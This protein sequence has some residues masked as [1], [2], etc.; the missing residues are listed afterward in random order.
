MAL[1]IQF[2]RQ[3]AIQRADADRLSQ[4]R[5]AADLVRWTQPLPR[6]PAVRYGAALTRLQREINVLT[7]AALKPFI[8]VETA[9][10]QD[11]LEPMDP[12]ST[13]LTQITK[14]VAKLL[15]P[16]ALR[17]I[18]TPAGESVT[19]WNGRKYDNALGDVL[20]INDVPANR[21][22][23][24]F[25]SWTTEN[26]AL[27]QGS[28]QEQINKIRA[29]MF[30][31]QRQGQRASD[32]ENQIRLIMESTTQRARLI[33]RD[34]TTKFNGQLD[35]LKQTNAGITGYVWRTSQD[36]RVRPSHRDLNGK[37][38]DW[39]KPPA[40]G[41]PGQDI[42]C[43]CVAEPDVGALLGDKRSGERPNASAFQAITPATRAAARRRHAATIKAEQGSVQAARDRVNAARR[44]RAA[45][46]RELTALAGG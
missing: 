18:I 10:R 29:L 9:A 24:M 12:T 2:R 37:H 41:A 28:N 11:A 14:A 4:R 13:L 43:R 38:F 26:V 19:A 44:E 33:A 32:T 6:G 25:E 31:A 20:A 42:Q 30:R 35:R 1:P 34:Q 23:T 39:D 21:I 17:T 36:E 15:S 7:F 46:R 8:Q 22:G 40:V 3:M 45:A 16:S 5:A 27:I